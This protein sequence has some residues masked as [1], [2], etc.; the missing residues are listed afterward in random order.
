MAIPVRF[1]EAS[2]LGYV[3][4]LSVGCV[5]SAPERS[6]DSLSHVQLGGI[7]QAVLE[8]G[9]HDRLPVLLWLHGGPGAAQMPLAHRYNTDLEDSMIVVHWDQRGAGKSNPKDF[10]QDS[11][12]VRQFVSDAH[13]LTQYLKAKYQQD[14]IFVLGHS[15]GTKLGLLLV[16]EQ[17]ELGYTVKSEEPITAIQ[18]QLSL[19]LQSDTARIGLNWDAGA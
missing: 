9:A 8:R 19:Q 13:E 10:D 17:Q 3:M 1:A 15:W 12:T 11:M 4:L 2:A 14:R 5:S 16:R 18:R 6:V 7:E